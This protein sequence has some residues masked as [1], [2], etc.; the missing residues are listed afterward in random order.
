MIAHDDFL[1][2]PKAGRLMFHGDKDKESGGFDF[3][4]FRTIDFANLSQWSEEAQQLN[5]EFIMLMPSAK[6]HTFARI[7][8]GL[9]DYPDRDIAFLYPATPAAPPPP[10]PP[11]PG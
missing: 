5:W 4:H 7:H 10:P 3:A 9:S 8:R 2:E 6:V 1:G 11:S